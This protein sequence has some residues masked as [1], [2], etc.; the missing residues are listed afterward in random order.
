VELRSDRIVRENLVANALK[1]AHENSWDV[2]KH[3][4]LEL[5]DTLVNSTKRAVSL[6]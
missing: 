2:R 5:V 4:Y 6:R 1:Y 3:E